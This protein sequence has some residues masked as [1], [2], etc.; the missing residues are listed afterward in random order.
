MEYPLRTVIRCS[1]DGQTYGSVVV[2]RGDPMYDENHTIVGYKHKFMQIRRG[3]LKGKECREFFDSLD[4][5]H[6]SLGL[7][8]NKVD[9]KVVNCSAVDRM[10]ILFTILWVTIIGISMQL[11]TVK[12]LS[13]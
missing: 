9:D 3:H 12:Y 2:V 13:L 10:L 1:Q 8:D 7:Y 4:E 6:E 11:S 5:W